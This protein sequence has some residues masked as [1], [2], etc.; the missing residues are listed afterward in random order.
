MYGPGALL[1]FLILVTLVGLRAIEGALPHKV[2]VLASFTFERDHAPDQRALENML[3]LHDVKLYDV[4]YAMRDG[5]R[6]FEYS[7]NLVTTSDSSLRV[8]VG[9][10]KETS[11]LIEFSLAKLSR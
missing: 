2:Y 10:L 3:G 1:T 6:Q 9:Q 4:S 5:G 8:L 7:A 11:G